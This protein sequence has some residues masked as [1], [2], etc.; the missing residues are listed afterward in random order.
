MAKFILSNKAIE[1]LS[2]IWNYTFD[3][4][5]ESQAD[6]YYDLLLETC[7]LLANK[8]ITGKVYPE[9]EDFIYGIQS[10]KHTIFYMFLPKGE[11]QIVRILHSRMDFK[12]RL[13]E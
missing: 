1:D 5:A 2:N 10:G 6:K 13:E 9:I 11:I 12:N 3:I 7:Q 8:K 4:W